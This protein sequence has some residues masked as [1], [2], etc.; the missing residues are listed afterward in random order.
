MSTTMKT[1][2]GIEKRERKTKKLRERESKETTHNSSCW[3]NVCS[4]IIKT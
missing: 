2:T 3:A 4:K 1:E